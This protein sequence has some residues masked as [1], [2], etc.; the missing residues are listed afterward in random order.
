MAGQRLTNKISIRTGVVE[1]AGSNV[2]YFDND[3]VLRCGKFN[4]MPGASSDEKIKRM[5]MFQMG[6]VIGFIGSTEAWNGQEVKLNTT[7][8]SGYN[9]WKSIPALTDAEWVTYKDIPGWTISDS[10]YHNVAN[11][12]NNGKGDPCKLVGLAGSV[13]QSMTAAE[14]DNYKSGRRTPT[15]HEQLI[16][17]GLQDKTPSAYGEYFNSDHSFLTTVDGVRG[18]MLPVYGMDESEKEFFPIVGFRDA[19]KGKFEASGEICYYRSAD[20]VKGTALAYGL[21]LF[22]RLGYTAYQFI[23]PQDP[24]AT[25]TAGL[26][27]RCTADK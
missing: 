18:A 12:K 19:T 7:G 2:L 4:D 20:L 15:S 5:A 1:G 22:Y 6:S 27:V 23:A 9:N 14:I 11:V 24:G 16:F 25:F 10:C 3:D 26:T 13:I 8:G 17:C 21:K